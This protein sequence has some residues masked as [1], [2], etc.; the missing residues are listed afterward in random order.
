LVFSSLL[1]V[2]C[3]VGAGEGD[4]VGDGVTLR[5][6]VELLILSYYCVRRHQS[7]CVIRLLGG[8]G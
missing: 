3:P 2:V 6:V 8:V 5:V 1:G 7:T 4:S